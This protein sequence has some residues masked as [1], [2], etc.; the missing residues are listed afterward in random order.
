MGVALQNKAL[1]A[2]AIIVPINAGLNRK[3]ITVDWKDVR[4]LA[5]DMQTYVLLLSETLARKHHAEAVKFV[6]AY[7]RALRWYKAQVA[8]NDSQLI[9]IV[10]KWTRMSEPQIRAAS[11]TYYD[12]DG[13]MNEDSII[14]QYRSYVKRGIA[15]AGLDMSKYFDKSLRQDALS[16]LK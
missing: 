1:D 2:A 14:D 10:S 5:P 9:E 6:R 16:G 3:G 13:A 11:W 7:I 12:K 4:Q 8:G 15:K